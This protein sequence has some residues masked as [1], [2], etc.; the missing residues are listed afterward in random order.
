MGVRA[1]GFNVQHPTLN[2]QRSRGR[3]RY[4]WLTEQFEKLPFMSTT[5]LASS[6][7]RRTSI[8]TL[9]E[10][11]SPFYRAMSEKDWKQFVDS[12]PDNFHMTIQNAAL[13]LSLR[14]YNAL[15]KR[16][17]DEVVPEIN[18]DTLAEIA[19]ERPYS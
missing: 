19:G 2:A 10:L 11:A 17:R 7:E 5:I 1:N 8:N 13:L 16:F 3:R 15:D 4:D 14:K 12:K 6:E 9:N 18:K